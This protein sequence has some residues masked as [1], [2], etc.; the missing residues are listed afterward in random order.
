MSAEFVSFH[1]GGDVVE[2]LESAPEFEVIAPDTS[3]RMIM[4]AEVQP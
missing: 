2:R 3:D 4:T 1:A